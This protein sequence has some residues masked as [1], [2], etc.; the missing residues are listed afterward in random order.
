MSVRHPIYRPSGPWVEDEQ[1]RQDDEPGSDGLTRSMD[2]GEEGLRRH[3]V[4]TLSLEES[5]RAKWRRWQRRQRHR[6]IFRG[7]NKGEEEEEEEE[8]STTVENDVDGDDRGGDSEDKDEDLEANDSHF[9]NTVEEGGAVTQIVGNA[10]VVNGGFLA[11]DSSEVS[12]SLPFNPVT[13]SVRS[14][15]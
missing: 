6:V 2:S 14:Q 7:S 11:D 4:A 15:N 3:S 9:F 5:E 1:S 10:G 12:G 8:M 13:A